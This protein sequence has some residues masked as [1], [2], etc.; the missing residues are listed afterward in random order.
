M[1]THNTDI[2]LN[3]ND[4]LP[5]SEPYSLEI[6]ESHRGNINDCSFGRQDGSVLD[7]PDENT[8]IEKTNIDLIK[9]SRLVVVAFPS[10][11]CN[12]EEESPSLARMLSHKNSF[13]KIDHKLSD[14]SPINHGNVS[15][16]ESTFRQGLKYRFT[17]GLTQQQPDN[18]EQKPNSTAFNRSRTENVMRKVSSNHELKQGETPFPIKKWIFCKI[19]RLG[20][21]NYS[22]NIYN[23]V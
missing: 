11:V 16:L 1:D 15:A 4:V 10:D 18:E 23:K 13:K 20:E 17:K 5:T 7:I 12:I 2:S 19:C 9:Y 3:K 14:C 6:S 8:S 22:N 21:H